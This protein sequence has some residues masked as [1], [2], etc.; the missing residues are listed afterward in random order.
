M[1]TNGD[2]CLLKPRQLFAP[3]TQVDTICNFLL[4]IQYSFFS[5]NLIEY[6]IMLILKVHFHYL[7]FFQGQQPC[8]CKV[9]GSS[10]IGGSGAGWEGTAVLHHG[11]AIKVGCL[12]FVFS[13]VD[14]APDNHIGT[15]KIKTEDSSTCTSTLLPVHTPTSSSS[16]KTIAPSMPLLSSSS[17]LHHQA[18]STPYHHNSSST[19]LLK[20]QLKSSTGSQSSSKAL[21]SL[22]FSCYRCDIFIYFF[23]LLFK[24]I[25]QLLIV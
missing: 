21:P 20:T 23:F 10:L 2:C 6:Y 5:F 19:S 22:L 24:F 3:L 4:D 12:Q 14:Q 17:Y 9:S 13:I 1:L 11:S 18:S 8:N 15:N 16:K 7:F 25:G